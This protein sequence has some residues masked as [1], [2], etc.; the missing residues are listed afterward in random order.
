MFH[1]FYEF[2]K[3]FFFIL[4][5]CYFDEQKYPQACDIYRKIQ[6]LEPHRLSGMEYY[7]T[8]L[9]YRED[10]KALSGMLIF[11]AIKFHQ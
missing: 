5:R 7:S 11:Y 1:A 8:C 6:K 2:E 3:I 10:A 9:F 4:A